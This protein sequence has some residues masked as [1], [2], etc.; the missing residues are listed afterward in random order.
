MCGCRKGLVSDARLWARDAARG[1]VMS[2]L[3]ACD[4]FP[5][6]ERYGWKRCAFLRSKKL[7]GKVGGAFAV[8]T[9]RKAF[10][11]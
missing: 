2:A 6:G 8:C 4:V 5:C 11:G 7:S 1:A 3:R 10:W 9:F